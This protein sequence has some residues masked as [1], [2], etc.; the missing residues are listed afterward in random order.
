MNLNQVGVYIPVSKAVNQFALTHGGAN[1]VTVFFRGQLLELMRWALLY[2]RNHPNDGKTFE[3]PNTRRMFV[4]AALIASDL[5]AK[6][7]YGNRFSLEGGINI[8]RERSLGAIRKAIEGTSLCAELTRSF[9]RGWTIF[10]DYFRKQYSSLDSEFQSKVGLSIEDYFKCLLIIT[11]HFANP[12]SNNTGIFSAKTFADSTPLRDV[13]QKYIAFESQSTEELKKKL[14][15][16][17]DKLEIQDE[18]AYD[19]LSMRE[20]PILRAED[21]RAIILDPIFYSEKASIGPLFI[22]A[23]DKICGKANEVFSAFGKAFENYACGILNKMFPDINGSKQLFCNLKKK[24]LNGRELEIDACINKDHELVIF[25][26]KAV[27]IREDKILNEN[28]EA[29]L[30]HLREKYGVVRQQGIALSK[31]NVTFGN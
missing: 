26:I 4:Q 16:S 27:W 30:Q 13:F 5:W 23:K 11:V 20:K 6:W 12:K 2:C 31:Q 28:Y 29:Y 14:W 19:Y 1:R 15:G 7:V 9:G 25:E 17:T 24:D 8:A 22:L 21:D 3:D 18:I 10:M